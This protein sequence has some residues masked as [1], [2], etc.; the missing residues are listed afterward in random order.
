MTREAWCFLM[1]LGAGGVLGSL[2]AM[3]S[4]PAASVVAAAVL[5]TSLAQLMRI[6][7]REFFGRL[8]GDDRPYSEG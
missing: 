1:M 3:A 5:L 6:D 8:H 7:E 2:G 4:A